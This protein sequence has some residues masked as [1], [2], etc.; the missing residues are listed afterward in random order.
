MKIE[1][2]KIRVPEKQDSDLEHKRK[3]SRTSAY[4][5]DFVEEYYNIDATKLI[6]FKNQA[7]KSFDKESL[8]SLASTIKQHGIRQ[9]LTV[10][11]SPTMEGK[12]EIVSGERRYRAGLLVGKKTMP[13]IILQDYKK[14]NEIAIIENIQREN[15]HP[16]ELMQAYSN[17]LDEEICFS[18]GD[19][20]SKLGVSKSSVVEV[21][22]LRKLSSNVRDLLLNNKIVSREFL[23]TL[24]KTPESKHEKSINNF[25]EYQIARKSSKKSL[26]KRVF[27]VVIDEKGMA[28]IECAKLD[29]LSVAQKND[30]KRL[31]GSVFNNNADC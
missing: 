18:M 15:L 19:I 9:P 2:A 8:E 31:I 6:P 14:A 29:H 17:L 20:A 21:L 12:Y 3:K 10:V 25:L 28:N 5:D 13:C 30:V 22:N 26:R 16:V 23:R 1:D 4:T 27:S 7:R 11:V 24:L